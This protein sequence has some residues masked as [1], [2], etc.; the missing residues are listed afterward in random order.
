MGDED[1]FY[2]LRGKPILFH[3]MKDLLQVAGMP[4]I[5]EYR[6]IPIDHKRIAIVLIGI[7]PEVGIE[8]LFQFHRFPVN[9]S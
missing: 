4:R 7:P 3:L 1:K 8:T 2:L 6:L 5:D 9:L